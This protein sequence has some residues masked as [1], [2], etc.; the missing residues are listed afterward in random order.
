MLRNE[1]L[2]R[3]YNFVALNTWS[4]LAFRAGDK[5]E[6]CRTATLYNHIFG[7]NSSMTDFVSTNC[8]P[9]S[10]SFS[11]Q[12]EYKAWLSSIL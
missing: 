5:N 12:R 1:F 8:E 2:K 11:F 9:P 10:D 7:N 6:G 3:P 4:I